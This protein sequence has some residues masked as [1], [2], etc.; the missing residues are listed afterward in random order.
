LENMRTRLITFLFLLCFAFLDAAQSTAQTSV[1]RSPLDGRWDVTFDIPEQQYRTLIEFIVSNDGKVK[2]TVLGYPILRF[3]EGLISENNLHLKGTSPYGAIQINATLDDNLFIGRWQ[4]ALLSGEVRGT[5]SN[6]NRP[7]VS[8]RNVFDSVWETINQRFYDPQFNGVDWQ[9]LRARYRPQAESARTDGELVTLIR[10]ML[11]ELHSSH[12]SF[13]ALSL[14][15]SFVASKAKTTGVTTPPIV[16]RKLLAT[17]GYLQIRQFE[18]S[19]EVLHL[20]DSAFAELGDIPS[21]IID[22]RGNPGGTLSAAMRLGDYLFAATR[23][24]GYFVTRAGLKRLKAKSI[25][26]IKPA[27]LPTYSGYNVIDFGHELAR[28]GAVMITT[29]GRAKLYSGRIVLLIDERCG[30]TTEGFASV[31]KERRI[32]TLIGRRTAGAMLSSVEVQIVGGWTLR[33]P[34]ADFLTPGGLRVEGKGVEPDILVQ[35][36]SSGDADLG[37]ALTFLQPGITR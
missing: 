2:A 27:K 37:R 23:P 11:G 30:S 21:L 7:A 26:Q 10:N 12:L 22:V 19:P 28:S 24:V 14:E 15:Q 25:D 33:L 3:T 29:G 9:S 32:A 4:V 16:W 36:G 1:G 18:E 31:V 8:R 34:E 6:A 5:R 20:V 17:V 35:K 13:S